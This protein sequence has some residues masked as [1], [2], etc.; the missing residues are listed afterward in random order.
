MMEQPHT[1]AALKRFFSPD[2]SVRVWDYGADFNE[3]WN[4]EPLDA[5]QHAIVVWT[6]I[7]VD[8]VVHPVA[9]AE[10]LTPFDWALAAR[11]KHSN[12]RVTVLDLK[13]KS[14]RP[15]KVRCASVAAHADGRLRAMVTSNR[16]RQIGRRFHGRS[17]QGG[18]RS[19]CGEAGRFS[20]CSAK[21]RCAESVEIAPGLPSGYR[22]R[23]ASRDREFGWTF[24]AAS[25]LPATAASASIFPEPPEGAP[26]NTHRRGY[27]GGIAKQRRARKNSRRRACPRRPR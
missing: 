5:T 14:T 16:R 19:A 13:P 26:P 12:L 1:A 18:A 4:V 21:D 15:S 2:E 3:M 22:S 20:A 25:Q 17:G 8:P 6:D 11:C 9:T 27:R 10:H 7:P 23:D 24:A